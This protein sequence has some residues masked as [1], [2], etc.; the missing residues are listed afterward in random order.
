MEN[1]HWNQFVIMPV[2]LT[3][4]KW[5]LVYVSVCIFTWKALRI[6]K[7]SFT[8]SVWMRRQHEIR[9][10]WNSIG[11]WM[12]MRK[13]LCTSSARNNT[14]EWFSITLFESLRIYDSNVFAIRWLACRNVALMDHIASYRIDGWVWLRMQVNIFARSLV[15]GWVFRIFGLMPSSI[16]TEKH[17]TQSHTSNTRAHSCYETH[18]TSYLHKCCCHYEWTIRLGFLLRMYD[19]HPML[20]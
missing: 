16:N 1:E 8:L 4:G 15:P 20:T 9:F 7:S 14:L 6:T 3:D 5:C 18:W 19:M 2:N 10:L 12:Q 11:L 13:L 17:R